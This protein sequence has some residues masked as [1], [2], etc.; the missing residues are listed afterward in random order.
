MLLKKLVFIQRPWRSRQY[1]PPK[2]IITHRSYRWRENGPP[3]RQS[4]IIVPEDIGNVFRRTVDT[5]LTG[6]QCHSPDDHSLEAYSHVHTKGGA[7]TLRRS[8]SNCVVSLK[9]CTVSLVFTSPCDR[10]W[11]THIGPCSYRAP[12][13]RFESDFLGPRTVPCV[14]VCVCVCVCE[15]VCVWVCVN[16]H[17]GDVMMFTAVRLFS[18]NTRTVFPFAA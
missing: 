9:V 7:P 12:T 14:C 15:R 18:I 17:M 2:L 13:D 6:T 4:S 1:I 11:F 10:V 16:W 3:K 5:K 8:R